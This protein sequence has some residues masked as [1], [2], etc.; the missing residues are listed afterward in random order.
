MN[1]TNPMF[2][3]SPTAQPTQ[4]EETVKLVVNPRQFNTIIAGLGELPYKISN[5]V[6]QDL[7]AQVQKQFK[8][9]GV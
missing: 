5:D 3:N 8:T 7:V 4:Q 2:G 9:P 1:D 6:L